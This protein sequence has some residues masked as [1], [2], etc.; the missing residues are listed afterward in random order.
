MALGSAQPEDRG[1]LSHP[2]V[3]GIGGLE[4][5][6]DGILESQIVPSGLTREILLLKNKYDL[7]E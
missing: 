5:H 4:G 7:M 3:L 1:D 6:V 2:P